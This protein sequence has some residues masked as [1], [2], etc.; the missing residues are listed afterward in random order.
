MY[1]HGVI[2]SFETSVMLFVLCLSIYNPMPLLRLNFIGSFSAQGRSRK[3]L[4][5]KTD[6]S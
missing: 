3:V 5:S 6:V 1:L 4:E 2:P